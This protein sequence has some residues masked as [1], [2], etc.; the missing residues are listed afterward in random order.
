MKLE[1][2]AKEYSD[3]KVEDRGEYKMCDSYRRKSLTKFDGY[4]VE[5]AYEDGGRR[6]LQEIDQAIRDKKTGT[7]FGDILECIRELKG[8]DR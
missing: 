1:D 2:L 8:E 7:R 5:Q 6:V 3:Q 4:D